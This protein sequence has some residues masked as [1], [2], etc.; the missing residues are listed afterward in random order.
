MMSLG[1]IFTFF[2]FLFFF[3]RGLLAMGNVRLGNK[4]LRSLLIFF[5]LDFVGGRRDSLQRLCLYF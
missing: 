5:M 2:G 4:P 1:G 3:D